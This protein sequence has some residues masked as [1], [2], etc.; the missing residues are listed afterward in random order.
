MIEALW[1][2]EFIADNRDYGAG[3][4]VF[5]SGRAFGGDS[6]YYYTGN[7]SVVNGVFSA[8]ITTTHYAGDKNNIVG[9]VDRVTWDISGAVERDCFMVSGQAQGFSRKIVAR[10]T[11]RGELP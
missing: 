7:Y 2:V 3:I 1:S 8:E 4:I 5:E 9:P 6:S 11:R 10:L